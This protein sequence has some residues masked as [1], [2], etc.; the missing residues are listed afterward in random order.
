VRRI[1]VRR[2]AQRD[3]EAI[4]TLE[5]A[6]FGASAWPASL[7]EQYLEH[8]GDLFLVACVGGRVAAYSITCYGPTRAELHSIAVHPRHRRT[9][10]AGRL[11]R[12]S[13]VALRHRRVE[14]WFLTVR[15]SNIEAIALYR[16]FGFEPTR[17]LRAYYE[18][19]EDGWRMRK[20]LVYTE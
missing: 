1:H 14:A 3:I 7:F 15:R 12:R 20:S 19:G 6:S 9:G 5:K 2:A 16:R 18:D 11:L 8:C 13:E 17:G 10:L 4:V